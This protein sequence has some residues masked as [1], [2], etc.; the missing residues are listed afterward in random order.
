MSDQPTDATPE[1]P[2]PPM[3]Q[4]P[5]TP[6]GPPSTPG[7][8]PTMPPATPSQPYGAM[9]EPDPTPVVVPKPSM[10][11]YGV[12]G[13]VVLALGAGAV[14]V[15]TSGGG[16]AATVHAGSP[17]AAVESMLSVIGDG[18][19]VDLLRGEFPWMSSVGD[20]DEA[21][22]AAGGLPGGRISGMSLNGEGLTYEVE[23]IGDELAIVSFTGGSLH[24]SLDASQLPAAFAGALPP[25]MP[26][27]K[28]EQ[29]LPIAGLEAG[30]CASF[31]ETDRSCPGIEVVTVKDAGGW[32]V[33][34][35]HTF[36]HL[37]GAG[38]L[39]PRNPSGAISAADIEDRIETAID[40]N[41]PNAFFDLLDPEEFSWVSDFR[42]D[43]D[44]ADE[45]S[46]S[47]DLQFE[48][49]DETAD[50]AYLHLTGFEAR[51]METSFGELNPDTFEFEEV[52]KE[53]LTT[54]DGDCVVEDGGEPTCLS[55]LASMD[56]GPFETAARPIVDALVADGIRLGVVQRDGLWYLSVATTF[57]PYAPA[58]K[59][60][61]DEFGTIAQ[62]CK[63]AFTGFDPNT[64]DGSSDPFADVPPV[65][66]A[67]MFGPLGMLGGMSSGIDTS[68]SLPGYTGDVISTTIP[69]Y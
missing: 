68:G 11:R 45:P 43:T 37:S 18:R 50:S 51:S 31:D 15:A 5:E 69:G 46:A 39:E 8:P 10:A 38:T 65:C 57:E 35:M 67:L 54:F 47:V 56:L 36:M 16:S 29:T 28:I 26:E 7:G 49:E 14:Y 61:A 23:E 27:T 34:L 40:A 6:L 12:I 64:Y 25:G 24:F 58:L 44:S 13:A 30:M 9:S 19:I 55:D 3:A 21:A 59:A 22:L 60:A 66:Q 20:I 32:R 2:Q 62:E 1:Q 48:V 17:T 33:S 63:D 4:P 42:I 52:T 53:K 41:D